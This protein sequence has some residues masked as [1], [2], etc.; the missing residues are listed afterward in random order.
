MYNNSKINHHSGA[1]FPPLLDKENSI[2]RDFEC[3]PL[4]L[5]CPQ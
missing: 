5:N 2:Q 1:K 3:D 4:N